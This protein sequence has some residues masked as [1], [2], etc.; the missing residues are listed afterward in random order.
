MHVALIKR[1]AS[2]EFYA[3]CVDRLTDVEYNTKHKWQMQ[4]IRII[5]INGG[6]I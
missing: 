6:T 3:F 5:T 1:T 2:A 4:I